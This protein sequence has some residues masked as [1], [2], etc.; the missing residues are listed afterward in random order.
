[1]N[2]AALANIRSLSSSAPLWTGAFLLFAILSFFPA[3]PAFAQNEQASVSDT[4][5][6]G[7]VELSAR[8]LELRRKEEE[9]LQVMNGIAPAQQPATEPSTARQASETVVREPTEKIIKIQTTDIVEPESKQEPITV[10][11]AVQEHVNQLRALEHHPALDANRPQ[12]A[13]APKAPNTVRTHLPAGDAYDGT[14]A[15]RVGTFKR[16]DRSY[17]ETPRIERTTSRSRMV[18]LSE[19]EQEASIRNVSLSQE[20]LA[21]IKTTATKLRTGPTKLDTTLVVLPQY[22][23][24]S[25]DY[26]SGSWYRV[27]TETGMRGWVPGSALLF[28]A[29]VSP[30]SA[31]R[32]GAITGNIR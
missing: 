21:T 32:V 11:K 27:R 25:I 23:E 9:L 8:E 22:S 31:V 2:T 19:I 14:T 12:K 7:T 16:V 10:E 17:S 15:A 6:A 4:T 28:D 18:P 26:R 30:R 1:M 29:G 5:N 24:V 3:T 13:Q 20:E